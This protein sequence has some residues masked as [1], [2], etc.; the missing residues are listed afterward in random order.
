MQRALGVDL[1]LSLLRGRLELR[2][3]EAGWNHVVERG[4]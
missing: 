2:N 3:F 4:S 1:V